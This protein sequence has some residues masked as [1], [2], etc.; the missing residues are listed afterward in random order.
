MPEETSI[1]PALVTF[2]VITLLPVPPVLWRT[3]WLVKDDDVRQVP[4]ASV[5]EPR[6]VQALV[7]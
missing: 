3:P 1:D 7:G 6:L 2:D 5:I 4:P